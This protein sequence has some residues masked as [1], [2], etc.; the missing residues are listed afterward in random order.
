[1]VTVS[2]SE[3][4]RNPI[5]M[6]LWLKTGLPVMVVTCLVASVMFVILFEW[7]KTPGT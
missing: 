4:T 1:V 7:M 3:R 2:L 6:K 5:T